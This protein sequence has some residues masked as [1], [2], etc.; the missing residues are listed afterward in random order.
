MTK[1]NFF[2]AGAPRCGT[3]AL[4]KYLRGHPNVF[5]PSLKEPHFFAADMRERRSFYTWTTG[6]YF[7]LFHEVT[8]NHLAI[9]EAS[10]FYLYS[11]KAFQEIYRFNHAAKIIVMLRNPVDLLA[12]LHSQM[13]YSATERRIDFKKA[14]R[15]NDL[16][17]GRP[18]PTI[19][20]YRQ[21]GKLGACVERLYSIFPKHQVKIVLLED[22]QNSPKKVYEK[23]L[24]FLGVPSDHRNY[25]PKINKNKKIRIRALGRLTQRPP[26]PLWLLYRLASNLTGGRFHEV[27]KSV[28][29]L[30]DVVVERKP[31]C[32]KLR[33]EMVEV[34]SD[35]I[36]TLSSAINKD[37]S[38]WKS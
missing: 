20:T 29:R 3:T 9:G 36:E 26:R 11:A 34:F 38:H 21:A 5:L 28:V 23:I 37:L 13:I 7:A 15:E 16:P 1:P 24:R 4:Y 35:D 2:I 27:V 22:F 25:F 8:D 6:E 10:V 32:P 17:D 33:E 18:C 31:V 19:E 14:W 12:S 30:N